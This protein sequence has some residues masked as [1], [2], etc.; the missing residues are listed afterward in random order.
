MGNCIVSHFCHTAH[1]NIQ[2]RNGPPKKRLP[3]NFNEGRRLKGALTLLIT[4]EKI[5]VLFVMH[6]R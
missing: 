5:W 3:I 1:L 2:C 6:Q 4:H